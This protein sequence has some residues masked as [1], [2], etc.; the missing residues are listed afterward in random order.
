MTNRDKVLAA[1][2]DYWRENAIPPTIRAIKTITG[3]NSTSMVRH[4][5]LQLE[6]HGAI[7]RIRSKPV[8]VKIYQLITG[9]TS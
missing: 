9:E 1:I 4:Y 7:K 6:Q 3:I 5:C 2:T 8:P